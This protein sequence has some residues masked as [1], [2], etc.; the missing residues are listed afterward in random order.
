M[1]ICNVM[2]AIGQQGLQSF[3]GI[4]A[5]VQFSIINTAGFVRRI[6]ISPMIR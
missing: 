3:A 2:S 4:P 5:A 6:G 1:R